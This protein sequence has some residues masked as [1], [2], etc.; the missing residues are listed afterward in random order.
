MFQ[1]FPLIANI[2]FTW[3]TLAKVFIDYPIKDYSRTQISQLVVTLLFTVPASIDASH[4]L[5]HRPQWGFKILG[6]LNM[7]LFQ[8]TVYPIEHI[9]LHHKCVGTSKD[10]ITSPKNQ[11]FYTYTLK[12][13]FSAHKFVFNYNIKYFA[14]CLLTN[15]FYIGLL[16]F[17]AF[18]EYND[19]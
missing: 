1:V 10:P 9:Y 16:F 5:I 4:E 8:F 11:N 13:F 12:A 18:K 3:V 14:I 7:A 6:F 15:W 17:F 2:L 19:I